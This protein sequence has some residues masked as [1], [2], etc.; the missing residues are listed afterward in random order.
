MIQNKAVSFLLIIAIVSLLTGCERLTASLDGFSK[1]EAAE[2]APELVQEATV[3]PEQPE[4]SEDSGDDLTG[5]V[6][7]E[8]AAEPKS[9]TYTVKMTADGFSPAKLYIKAGDTVIWKNT[10]YG[11]INKAMIIGVRECSKVRSGFFKSGESFSW[12]FDTPMTC[13]IADGVMTTKE[14]KVFVE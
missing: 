11:T 9:T 2:T 8:V 5:D 10:R 13:T 3:A 12:T 4:A 14:S 1:E 6:I 7:A